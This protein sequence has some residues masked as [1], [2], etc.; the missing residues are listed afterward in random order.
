MNNVGFSVLAWRDTGSDDCGL[1]NENPES[2]TLG[3][4]LPALLE[5]IQ[6]TSTQH[7]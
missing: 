7:F 3:V 5:R 4:S 2:F 6:G 1:R